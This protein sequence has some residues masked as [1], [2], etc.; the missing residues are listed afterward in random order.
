MELVRVTEAAAMS[1]TK[2]YGRANPLEAENA[3]CRSMKQRLDL[4]D[5][6]GSII[7]CIYLLLLN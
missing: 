1:C 2:W 5:I 7:A 6:K 4:L 3:A